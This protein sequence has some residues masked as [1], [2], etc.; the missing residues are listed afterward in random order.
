MTSS[1]RDWTEKV[2]GRL[3]LWKVVFIVIMVMA[4]YATVIRFAKGLGAAT[5]LSDSFPWGL[6][7]GFD[8]LVGVGLAAGGFVLAATVH[9]FR[10]ERFEPI[11][12]P[13]VLTAFLGYLLVIFALLFDLGHPF[14]IWHPLVMWNPH[15]VMFEVGWCVT[16]Y[17]TVLAAEFSPIIFERLGWKKPLKV[18]K[19]IFVPLV[20]LGV[21][22]STL[23]QSSLGTFY[24]I[25]PNKLHGLWYTSLLPVFF[26]ISAVAGG[27]SMVIFESF[28]SRRAF[29]KK[30]EMNLLVDLARASVVV[31]AFLTVWRLQ[32]IAMRGNFHLIFSVTP[33]STLFWGEMSLGL[34]LPMILFALPRV[35]RSE[36]GLFFAATLT[37]MGF[38]MYRLNVSIT[39]MAASSGVSY[40][41]SWME[42][43]VTMGVVALGFA[44][45]GLAVKH[46]PVFPPEKSESVVR[47]V[48]LGLSGA[49]VGTI[50][51]KPLLALWALFI[52]GF[53]VVFQSSQTGMA[54]E[55][56]PTEEENMATSMA[57]GE[58]NLP[59]GFVFPRSDDSP[60][61]VT[62]NHDSHVDPVAPNCWNCH[63][64]SF[65]IIDSGVPRQGD[66]TY[67]RVHE[68]DL[69]ASCHDGEKAF[70]VIDDCTFCHQDYQ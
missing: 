61:S 15:S 44:L 8:V 29:G 22:L 16:L 68:G 59:G 34:I 70:A 54:S 58:L 62:F 1:I 56:L 11:V 7:I 57:D 51:L 65:S 33:E 67:E 4:A 35:R 37:I 24:V 46:L 17:T 10:I 52:V 69:C 9:I 19:A 53:I 21:I 27:L 31:L 42:L 30:L 18:V 40:V 45:F 14:R 3:T 48:E 64:R 49:P 66:I 55:V 60:G 26:F 5:N 12:R 39:G 2:S 63:T 28:M 47:K 13:T 6:W 25:V 23:H 43:A 32:D 41:P 38:I 20:I 36:S 50:T